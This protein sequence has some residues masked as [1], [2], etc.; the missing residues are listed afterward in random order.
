ML[1][2]DGRLLRR[3]QE[4]STVRLNGF[5]TDQEALLSNA[6]GAQSVDRLGEVEIKVMLRFP[7]YWIQ[8]R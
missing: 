5:A 8:Y 1:D 4:L 2:S 7:R 3:L 6:S